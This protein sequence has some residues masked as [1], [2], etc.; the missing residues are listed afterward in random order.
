MGDMAF[1]ACVVGLL[2]YHDEE[3]APFHLVECPGER[4]RAS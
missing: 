2:M 3:I 4:G 1:V